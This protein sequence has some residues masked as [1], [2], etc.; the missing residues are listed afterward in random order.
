MDKTLGILIADNGPGFDMPTDMLTK[1]FV[2]SRDGMGLG[3]HIVSEI[4]KSMNGRLE[5]PEFGEFDIPE[6]FKR[7]AIV[8][9]SIPKN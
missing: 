1:P 2:T 6:E 9:L 8:L 5:F 3:L 4:M 7:G